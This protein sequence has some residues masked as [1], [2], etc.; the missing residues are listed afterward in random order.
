[1]DRII[2]PYTGKPIEPTLLELVDVCEPIKETYDKEQTDLEKITELEGL[3]FR[4]AADELYRKI[5]L[6][7][8]LARLSEFCYIKITDEKIRNFLNNKMGYDSKNDQGSPMATISGF[9][10]PMGMMGVSGVGVWGTAFINGSISDAKPYYDEKKE[11]KF[12]QFRKELHNIDSKWVKGDFL[13]WRE[14]LVEDYKNIPP[15]EVLETFKIHRDR[16]I[17]DYFS[18]ASVEKIKDPLLLGRILGCPE[19]FFIAQWGDDIQLDDIL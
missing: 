11:D 19:R 12:E 3:G 16:K 17:F 4:W 14:S 13:Q 8:K 9:S 10:G 1:M 15:R 6:R 7:S 2:D 5:E 18:I